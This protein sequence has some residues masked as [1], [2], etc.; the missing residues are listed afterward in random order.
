MGQGLR[1]RRETHHRAPRPPRPPRH[2]HRHQGQELPDA[3]AHYRRKATTDQP[4]H[5]AQ[6]RPQVVGSA[7][8]KP[9]SR[10]DQ[11]SAGGL[12]QFSSGGS[13]RRP[14]IYDVHRASSSRTT[15][16]ARTRVSH[17]FES[18]RGISACPEWAGD[19]RKEKGN[20]KSAARERSSIAAPE[21]GMRG[22]TARRGAT[23]GLAKEPPMIA[24]PALKSALLHKGQDVAELLEAVLSG[25]N[26]DLG[27]LPVPFGPG[28]D[29]EL[30]LRNFLEQIHHAI[31]AFDTDAYGRCQLCGVDLDRGALQQQPWLAT[32]P[33]HAE[34][35]IS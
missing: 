6:T 22:R 30:R 25:K 15:P 19:K 17:D 14:Q 20:L 1:W 8:N 34:R 33:V 13:N 29:P 21:D 23:I 5:L 32:C 27:S 2:R 24:D 10:V 9:P 7:P 31:K 4:S 3:Q 28:Q 18:R 11:F 26:V 12:D 16:L 35:W